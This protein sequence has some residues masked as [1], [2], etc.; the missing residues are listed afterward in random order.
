MMV[1][2]LGLSPKARVG[3]LTEAQVRDIERALQDMSSLKI[4]Q[5][6]L[7]RVKDPETGE[8]KQV[9][10]T[11]LDI[12]TKNDIQREADV[13]SWRREARA[14]P[15]GEGAAHQDHGQGRQDRRGQKDNTPG[16]SGCQ[17]GGREQEGIETSH[18]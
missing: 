1:G 9:V 10:G 5:W 13:Q 16:G 7:N 14:R 11:D 3:L 2:T 12:M 8:T 17:D 18:G 15:Q 6:A 4:P